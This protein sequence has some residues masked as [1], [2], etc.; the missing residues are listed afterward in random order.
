MRRLVYLEAFSEGSREI[1]PKGGRGQAP[2]DIIPCNNEQAS[3]TVISNYHRIT[4]LCSSR[5]FSLLFSILLLS[6]PPQLQLSILSWPS[7]LI[8]H[9]HIY[10]QLFPSCTYI[11]LL[12]LPIFSCTASRTSPPTSCHLFHLHPF[13]FQFLHSII[14][15]PSYPCWQEEAI[16]ISD[17]LSTRI[18]VFTC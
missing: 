16:H 12:L 4:L 17:S 9:V 7:L 10:T 18:R 6:F 13:S 1:M 8:P 11:L 2:P 14:L 15:F 3:S 5:F